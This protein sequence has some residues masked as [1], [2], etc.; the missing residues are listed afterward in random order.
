MSILVLSNHASTEL[1][2]LIRRGGNPASAVDGH[3]RVLDEIL[4]ELDSQAA[5]FDPTP[6]ATAIAARVAKAGAAV[7][8]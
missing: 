6:V 1:A 4:A 7:V 5:G 2:G 8:A 3:P